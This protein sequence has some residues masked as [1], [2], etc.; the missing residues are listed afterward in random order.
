MT[1]SRA[2]FSIL[3]FREVTAETKIC[4]GL[5]PFTKNKLHQILSLVSPILS[6]ITTFTLEVI[7]NFCQRAGR[8]T[9]TL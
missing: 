6:V 9:P 2:D 4:I 7:Y 1:M 3:P 5:V 8:L